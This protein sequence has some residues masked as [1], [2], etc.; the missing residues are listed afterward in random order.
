[1][2]VDMYSLIFVLLCIWQLAGWGKT[3]NFERREHP[4]AWETVQGEGQCAGQNGRP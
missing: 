3:R 2:V 1:L 4:R